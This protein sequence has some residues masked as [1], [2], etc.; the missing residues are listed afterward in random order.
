MVALRLVQLREGPKLSN[1]PCRERRP[2]LRHR[3]QEGPSLGVI[4]IQSFGCRSGVPIQRRLTPESGRLEIEERLRSVLR[5]SDPPALLRTLTPLAFPLF[6]VGDEPVA[7]RGRPTELHGLRKAVLT[8]IAPYPHVTHATVT[9]LHLTD[10][11]IANVIRDPD[12]MAKR[13][14]FKLAHAAE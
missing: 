12:A 10:R 2:Q 11:Q 9:P 4:G 1:I 5:R 8:H 13:C 7:S 6:K 14:L 3:V